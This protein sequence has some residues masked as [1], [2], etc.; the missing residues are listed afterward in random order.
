[1]MWGEGRTGE[2]EDLLRAHS[3]ED[4]VPAPGWGWVLAFRGWGAGCRD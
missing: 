4:H 2:A 3:K 1:M